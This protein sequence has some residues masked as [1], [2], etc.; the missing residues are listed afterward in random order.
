M[1]R[2]VGGQSGRSLGA[3][4]GRLDLA[5][6]VFG[7]GDHAVACG[8]GLASA[9]PTFVGW[10]ACSCTFMRCCTCWLTRGW[11]WVLTVQD[12]AT[13]ILRA[14]LHPGGLFVRFVLLTSLALTSFNRAIRWLGAKRWQV[15]H[16]LV[17]AVAVL[18]VLH[19][20][21]MRAG[22]ND[23]AEVAWYAAVLAALLGWRVRRAL[24][25]RGGVP[26][27]PAV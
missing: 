2:P 24:G 14:A 25:A 10:R 4:D 3:L 22:K 13:D 17:Y 23:F 26:K 19:F 15:L 5:L 1:D 27:P 12:I 11:T 6:P 18:A 16:R 21:W 20:F 8:V 9:G 7:V